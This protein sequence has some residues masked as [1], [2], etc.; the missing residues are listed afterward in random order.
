MVER[1]VMEYKLSKI[2]V[3]L[4]RIGVYR[5]IGDWS[6]TDQETFDDREHE[7]IKKY[8]QDVFNN[9]MNQ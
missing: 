6:K 4:N 2:E 9:A 7:Y 8:N 5:K 1:I 3:T